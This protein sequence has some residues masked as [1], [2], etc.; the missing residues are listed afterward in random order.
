MKIYILCY[1]FFFF[2]RYGRSKVMKPATIISMLIAF[3]SAFSP[4]FWVFAFS[5]FL[6][7]LLAPGTIAMFFVVTSEITGP[8]YRPLAGIILWFFY[9]VGLVIVGLVGMKIHTWKMLM[10]YST[11][12]YFII[13]PFIL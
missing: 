7:G 2:Q 10:V 12:P 1:F 8:R 9:T 3:L 13:L 4:N 6:L 5:R 11:A